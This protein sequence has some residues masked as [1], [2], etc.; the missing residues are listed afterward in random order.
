MRDEFEICVSSQLE[1][2]AR[3]AEYISERAALAGLNEHQVFEVQMAIDEA[4]T[5]SMKH[6]YEG[7]EDGEV[8]V[9]C[10]VEDDDFVVRV[11]DSGKPFDPTAIPPP[12]LSSPLEDRQEGGLGLFLMRELMDSVEFH[13]GPGVGNQ[14]IMRKRRKASK[15]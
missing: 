14:V 9:C 5:N 8:S 4:C 15:R 2:L 13:A 11:T 12:D 1:N 6:A 7:R 3:I 10:Y